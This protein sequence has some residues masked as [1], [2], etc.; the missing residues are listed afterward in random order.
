MFRNSK[1]TGLVEEKEALE[2]S[3]EQADVKQRLQIWNEE[4]EELLLKASIPFLNPFD[5]QGHEVS[6]V[7]P[8][9]LR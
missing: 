6:G 4:Q 8:A 5:L 7:C 9:T 3:C 1:W 2:A